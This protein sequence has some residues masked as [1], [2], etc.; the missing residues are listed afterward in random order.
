MRKV[1]IALI[2]LFS[3]SSITG[4]A[5]MV[6]KTMASWMEHDVNDLIASWGPP[7]QT[8]S[9]GQGGQILVYSQARQWTTS[10][11]A[12]TNTYGQANTRGNVYGGTYRGNT[13]GTA[14]STTSY[15]PAQTHG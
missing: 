2:F 8:M 6:N 7:Q 5:S 15:T 10:G 11:Q 12:T 14:T 9:D 13:S 3:L 4:C 1:T